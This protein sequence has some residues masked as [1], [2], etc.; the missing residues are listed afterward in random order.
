MTN[1]AFSSSSSN[2]SDY[3]YSSDLTDPYTSSGL[4]GTSFDLSDNSSDSS[5]TPPY[6]SG[7]SSDDLIK[8][9]ESETPKDCSTRLLSDSVKLMP[10]NTKNETKFVELLVEVNKETSKT[11]SRKLTKITLRKRAK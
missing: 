3:C 11:F 8:F 5:D 2:I 7:F 1:S 6:F 10:E 9:T 4:H